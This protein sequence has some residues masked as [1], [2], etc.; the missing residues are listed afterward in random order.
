M[1]SFRSFFRSRSPR[2]HAPITDRSLIAE[3][4]T[5]YPGFVEFLI[6]RFKLS[7][8]DAQITLAQFSTERS[9]PP[10]VLLAEFQ[11][12]GRIGNIKM[13][14]AI[15]VRNRL[16]EFEVIDVRESWERPYGSI[17]GSKPFTSVLLNEITFQWPRVTPI[18]TY[19]HFGVRSLDA[20]ATLSEKGF[21]NVWVLEG[22]IDAWAQIDRSIR[23]YEH[24]WC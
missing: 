24:A 15:D 14:S 7:A 5:A 13:I 2:V 4:E 9:L 8:V 10:L 6:R 20:A 3:I 16:H 1:P 11:V 18:L 17:P 12:S 19:C 23:R 21:Q 22:G